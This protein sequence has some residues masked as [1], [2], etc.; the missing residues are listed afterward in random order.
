VGLGFELRTSHLKAGTLSLEPH[1]QP[2]LGTPL[3]GL[4][5]LAPDFGAATVCKPN[6]LIGF[7]HFAP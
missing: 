1:L 6:S 5:A 7:G 4:P 2:E 3:T